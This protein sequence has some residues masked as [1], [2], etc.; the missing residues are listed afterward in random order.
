[1]RDQEDQTD[2]YERGD[3]QADRGLGDP[4]LEKP[5]EQAGTRF[6]SFVYP[7]VADCLLGAIVRGLV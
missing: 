3:E 7:G 2:V 1:M 4:I 5:V 6:C